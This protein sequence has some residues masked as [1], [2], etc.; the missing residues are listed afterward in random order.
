MGSSSSPSSS[1][2]SSSSSSGS[3]VGR[4]FHYF[5]TD[6]SIHRGLEHMH[7]LSDK[8][9]TQSCHFTNCCSVTVWPLHHLLY[10]TVLMCS[11]NSF[12]DSP[13]NYCQLIVYWGIGPLSTCFLENLRSIAL[14]T[15]F[16]EYAMILCTAVS[17]KPGY[18]YYS[19][20][21]DGSPSL[22]HCATLTHE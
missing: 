2:S 9:H 7:N 19:L 11:I 16:L 14:L 18:Y 13:L 8:Q 1:S 22:S 12:C 15:R 4:W 21:V 20:P 3:N 5:T 6:H 17:L 10:G